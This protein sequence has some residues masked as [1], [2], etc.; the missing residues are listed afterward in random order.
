MHIQTVTQWN[1]AWRQHLTR[2]QLMGISINNAQ[3]S[4]MQWFIN[5]KLRRKNQFE[6]K[7]DAYKAKNKKR[8]QYDPSYKTRSEVDKMEEEMSEIGSII[9]LD[10]IVEDQESDIALQ[11]VGCNDCNHNICRCKTEMDADEIDEQDNDKDDDE[12]DEDV[13]TDA[14]WHR[15]HAGILDGWLEW[16]GL[17]DDH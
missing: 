12:K 5:R 10:D 6:E 17:N 3:R 8:R 2:L 14:D 13:A 11:D 16:F 1:D 15:I 9:S 4:D 7:G